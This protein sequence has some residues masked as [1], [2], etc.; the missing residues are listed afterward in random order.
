MRE[1]AALLPQPMNGIVTIVNETVGAFN[2]EYNLGKTSGRELLS[3]CRP[4]VEK[5]IFSKVYDQLFAM[6]AVK[7][8]E[9]DRAFV[10]K[11]Q[12]IRRY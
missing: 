4:C 5:Y 8:Q 10:E 3:Y 7:N 1:S 2:S 9:M 6:Y 12:A 11:A